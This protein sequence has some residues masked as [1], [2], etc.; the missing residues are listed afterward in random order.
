[1]SV[2]IVTQ[3]D[4]RYNNSI[5]RQLKPPQEQCLYWFSDFENFTKSFLALKRK[6]K[7][8]KENPIYGLIALRQRLAWY[9]NQTEEARK[10]LGSKD[11]FRV[12]HS[13]FAKTS[14]D[15]SALLLPFLFSCLDN[16]EKVTT[17]QAK[18]IKGYSELV[19]KFKPFITARIDI[20][21][22][23]TDGDFQIISLSDERANVK[24]PN[25]I[26]KN[27]IGYMIQS[28][29]GNLEL[30]VKSNVNG[31]IKLWFRGLDVRTSEGNAKR[32]PYW[33]DYTK[34][35]VNDEP[36]LDKFT[37]TWHDEP[38]VYTIDAKAN[39]EIKIQVEW[40][41]HRT[42]TIEIAPPPP[43]KVESLISDSFKPFITARIDTKLMSKEGDFQIVSVSDDK[44]TIEKPRWLQRGG[45]GYQLES[46]A[47]KLDFIAEATA[48]GKIQLKLRGLDTRDPE[49]NSKRIPYWIDYT[50]LTV[51]DKPIFDKITPAWLN[52]PYTYTIDAKADEEIKIHVEWQPHRSNT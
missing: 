9:L 36:I 49:D 51:N 38:Y 8:L 32:I 37:S 42:D 22:N 23:T 27:G 21:L 43:V 24:K 35:T 47:G 4:R 39:E 45:V 3:G 40:L 29:A 41:P 34:L 6:N 12:L 18:E 2:F 44:A 13:E 1:M 20:K 19:N 15:L 30:V 14:S 17:N 52:K 46:Y 50:K 10:E 25:W 48:D 28:Y 11:F 5:T 16:N 33:I 31:Q 7:V 26:Q